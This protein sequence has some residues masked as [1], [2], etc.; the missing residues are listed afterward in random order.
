MQHS[1][2]QVNRLKAKLRRNPPI[3]LRTIRQYIILLDIRRNHLLALSQEPSV[4]PAS[5][6]HIVLPESPILCLPGIRHNIIPLHP[7][8]KSHVMN[9]LQIPVVPRNPGAVIIQPDPALPL[10]PDVL[11]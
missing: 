8:L 1:V 10:L 3:L 6:F 7:I 9:K 5:K 4:P 11:K 2:L